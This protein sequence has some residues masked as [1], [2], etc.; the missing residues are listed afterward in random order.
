MHADDREPIAT[1]LGYNTCADFVN[2]VI[3]FVYHRQV[4][5]LTNA[6]LHVPKNL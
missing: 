5:Y 3:I 2:T 6:P 1:E 4:T